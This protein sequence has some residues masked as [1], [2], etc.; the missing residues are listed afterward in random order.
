[1]IK[2]STV[3]AIAQVH[4]ISNG[5]AFMVA[6][7]AS[8]CPKCKETYAVTE[9]YHSDGIELECNVCNYATQ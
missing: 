3:L 6:K 2:L 1:M 8:T 5:E 4:N 7:K 9:Y